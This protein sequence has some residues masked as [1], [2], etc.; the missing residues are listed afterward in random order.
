MGRGPRYRRPLFA[1]LRDSMMEEGT[2]ARLVERLTARLGSSE[3]S[4]RWQ[5]ARFLAAL[6]RS[7]SPAVPALERS[8]PSSDPATRVWVRAAL[9]CITGD[10][11][12]HLP[13]IVKALKDT[14]PFLRL[15]AAK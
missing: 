14:D 12:P 15:H 8:L 1:S 13:E 10:S 9:I 11:E 4:D 6:R 7:A 5:A 3:P 2:T